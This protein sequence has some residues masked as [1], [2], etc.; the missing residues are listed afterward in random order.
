MAGNS[1]GTL[2]RLTSFGESHGPALGG[3]IDGCPA[4]LLIDPNTIQSQLNRR[5]PG[6]SVFTTS[7]KETDTVE[8]LSGIFEGKSTGA[9][10]AFLVKNTNA[11]SVDYDSLKE[12]YR[13]SHADFSWD[14]KYGVRDHRGGGR[15]SA[16]ETISRVV[17]GA[18]AQTYLDQF[19]IRISA[20][21]SGI[22]ELSLETET[23]S[24][25]FETIESSVVRCP[26]PELSKKMEALILT[27][28]EQGDT[29]GGTIICS[30]KGLEAGLGE[31]VFHKF[32][33]DLAHAMMGI[34]A[35][36]GFE[37]GSGFAGCRSRGS[38]QNDRFVTKEARVH[39]LTNHSGGV[40]GGITNGE[41]VYFRLAFKPVATLMQAQST[42]DQKGNAVVIDPGGRHDVCVVPRAVPIV[43]AMAAIVTLD[44][45]LQ[46]RASR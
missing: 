38:L 34:N 24:F 28:R 32:Q 18:I 25:D 23:A 11:Q 35:V 40:Q 6:Q 15:S 16:R 21:V 20:Y 29:L 45:L 8:F 3:V 44:H 19:G 37:I 12:A 5:R 4:G 46:N 41:E 36:K 26:D 30:I 14:Q 43:E 33:A 27:V 9:P 2:F 10:I 1:I 13:P 31:P 22:G 7:R 17:A 39:T 42:V